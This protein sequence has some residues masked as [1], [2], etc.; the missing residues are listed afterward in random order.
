MSELPIERLSEVDQSFAHSGIDYFG[1]QLVKLDK[2][3]RAN[4]AAAKRYGAIF[5]CLSSRALHIELAEELST[6]SF[7]LALFRFMSRRGYPKCI[8]NDN[9]TNFVVAQREPSEALH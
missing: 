4:Q 7:I 9:G 1:L 2:K 3:T 5:T 6:G 8:T